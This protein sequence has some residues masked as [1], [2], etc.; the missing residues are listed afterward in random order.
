MNYKKNVVLGVALSLLLFSSSLALAGYE[1]E[2]KGKMKEKWAEKK[3][4]MYKELG[5]TPEQQAQLDAHKEKHRGQMKGLHEQIK[6]KREEVRAELQK[7]E[8]DTN[9]V[10]Q[11]HN[12][13]KALKAQQEDHQLEGVLEVRK[14][15]TAEQFQKFM[16]LKEDWK[17]KRKERF[18]EHFEKEDK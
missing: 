12:E 3:A 1:G 6:A 11:V 15:L 7:P 8:V 14:I 10:Q 13:L 4:E 2:H 17:N 9:K 5:L 16:Q 18:K